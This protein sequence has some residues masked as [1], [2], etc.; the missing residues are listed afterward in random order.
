M[1][2]VFGIDKYKLQPNKSSHDPQQS[3]FPSSELYGQEK[4]I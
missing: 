2:R 3:I 4:T 1:N